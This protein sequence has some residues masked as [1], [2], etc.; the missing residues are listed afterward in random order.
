MFNVTPL[1]NVQAYQWLKSLKDGK[2][3]YIAHK[4]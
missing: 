3:K 1:N 2:I 4:N